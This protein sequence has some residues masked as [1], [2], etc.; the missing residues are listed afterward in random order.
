MSSRSRD[1]HKAALGLDEEVVRF[2]VAKRAVVAVAGDVGDNRA[3]GSEARAR[4]SPR[5]MRHRR[6]R[7]EVLHEN[8]HA[9]QQP[10]DYLVHP[11]MLE[12]ER[13]RSPSND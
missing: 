10:V 2:L 9:L 11:G 3:W 12:V 7:R 1:G 13:E 8:V 6:T 4:R 5:P